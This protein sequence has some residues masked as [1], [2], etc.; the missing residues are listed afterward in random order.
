[1][2][3][4]ANSLLN[5]NDLQRWCACSRSFWLHRRGGPAAL[6]SSQP[7]AATGAGRSLWPGTRPYQS[8]PFQW[9]C[10][11]QGPAGSLVRHG[12]LAGTEGDPRRAFALTLLQVLGSTGAVLAYNAGFERNRIRELAQ[13]FDDLAPALDA[14]LARIVD[15][16]QI[17]R[18]H[19]YHP[20][21]AGSW[22]F[23]SVS[24]AV[25][26]GVMVDRLQGADEPS[27]QAAFAHSLKPGL[28]SAARQRLRAALQAH[29]QRETEVLRRMAALFE[30]AE[31]VARHG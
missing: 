19:Y 1:M 11:V 15:L 17:A 9:T 30:G 6:A 3:M 10:D 23:K 24:R 22:S 14:V 28:D 13:Q 5:H 4:A 20:A 29:G 18:A 21:M 8:L 25:A 26:P 2:F 7:P 27:V 31:A 12:F 16:F